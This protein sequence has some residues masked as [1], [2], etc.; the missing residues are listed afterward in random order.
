MAAIFQEIVSVV[1]NNTSLIWLG[2]ISKDAVNHTNE[3]SVLQRM[4]GIFNNGNDICSQLGN[5]KQITA[6]TVRE[7]D[8]IDGTF[9]ADNLLRG[10]QMFRQQLQCIEPWIQA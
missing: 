6:G 3:H 9:L 10:K 4:S 5:T 8:G 7:L 2:N 1:C